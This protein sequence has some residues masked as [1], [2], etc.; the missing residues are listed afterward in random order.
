[1]SFDLMAFDLSQAPASRRKF[2]AWYE[3]Q[4]QWSE[5][6]DYQSPAV[7]CAA[8]RDWFMEMKDAFPPMNGSFAPT[9]AQLEADPSLESRLADYSIGSKIIYAAFAWSAAEQAYALARRLAGKHGV[10][11]F[12]AGAAR[13]EIFR[14]PKERGR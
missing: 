3:E 11:L 5:E 14:G 8:L 10:G 9:D 13:G 4:T 7:T 2:L 6:H 1:M 12:A